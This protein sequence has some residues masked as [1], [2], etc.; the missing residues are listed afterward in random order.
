MEG[1][2]LVLFTS[3]YENYGVFVNVLKYKKITKLVLV[4]YSRIQPFPHAKTRHY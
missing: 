4:K 1:Q 3:D 2:T